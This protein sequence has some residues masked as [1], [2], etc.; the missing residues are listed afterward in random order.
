MFRLLLPVLVIVADAQQYGTGFGKTTYSVSD[1]MG[2]YNFLNTYLPIT[3][4]YPFGD[5]ACGALG[6][7]RT[8]VKSTS[9]EFPPGGVN[10]FGM[11]CVSLNSSSARIHKTEGCPSIADFERQ[12]DSKWSKVID[13]GAYDPFLDYNGGYWVSSL[14]PYITKFTASKV[15]VVKLS[16]KDTA[17]GKSYYSIMVRVHNSMMLVE[18]M[19]GD[20]SSCSSALAMPTA[21]FVFA[22]G[23]SPQDLWGSL[24]DKTSEKPILNP[25]RVSWPSSNLSREAKFFAGLEVDL[26]GEKQAE[27]VQTGIYDFSPLMPI[28]KTMQFHVVQ[29]ADDGSSFTWADYEA[30]VMKC[31]KGSI[32]DDLCG[33]NPFMD[34]HVGFSQHGTSSKKLDAGIVKKLS[35]DLGLPFHATPSPRGT[36]AIYAMAGN[37]LSMTFQIDQGSYKPPRTASGGMLDLCS[38]GN[39]AAS[40]VI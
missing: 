13:G 27:G 25:A 1:A 20:C 16:W 38:D 19:S 10:G 26:V 17:N 7:A 35:T 5:V 29:R 8:T 14:D 22:K 37:G 36:L 21:R 18:L 31:H 40:L 39:C 24:N 32:K 33:E 30:A 12:F 9:N 34:N 15:P 28:A 11:H 2:C 3:Q 4:D 6:R 23:Q